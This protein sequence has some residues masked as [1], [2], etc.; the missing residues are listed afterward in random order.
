M[1]LAKYKIKYQNGETNVIVADEA[2]VKQYTG[3]VGADFELVPN[4]EVGQ[5]PTPT[6]SYEE[7]LAALESAMMAMMMGGTGNV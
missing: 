5:Q 4:I 3:S 6:P 1:T 2:F 7:R